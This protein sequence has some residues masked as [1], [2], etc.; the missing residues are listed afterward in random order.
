MTRLFADTITLSY[1]SALAVVHDLTL[2][3]PDGAMTAIIGQNGCGKSTLLRA[4]ARLI[5]PRNGVVLLDGESFHRQTTKEVARQLGLLPQKPSAPEAIT[6][7]DLAHRGRYHHQSFFQP[8]SERDRVAVERALELASMTELRHRP[9]DELSGG[10]RQRAW[11]AMTLAQETPIL[12]LDE[13]TTY[14]D[15][16]HQQEVLALALRLNREEGRT[17]A[18]VLHDVN[19]AA[20][21]SDHVVAMRDGRIVA[22]GSP[23]CVLPPAHLQQ[24]FGVVCDV[25]THPQSLTP[26]S[27]P[28]G[29]DTQ[30]DDLLPKT[31]GG[32]LRT[33]RLSLGYGRSR[34]VEDVNLSLPQGQ[35]TAIVGPNA[36]G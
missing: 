7:E 36:S 23:G 33:E 9:V 8:S 18:M 13:P 17:V 12:L 26:I 22:E 2:S 35:I 6:V 1:R 10:Q 4:L 30:C 3:V 24:V 20:Q 11:I 14:L 19:N 28:R 25:V 31:V 32:A 29:A 15:I 34:V 5:T 21:V 27:V 16:A